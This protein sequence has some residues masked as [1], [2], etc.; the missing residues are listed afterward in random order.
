MNNEA[1]P[2]PDVFDM[3]RSAAAAGPN[4]NDSDAVEPNQSERSETGGLL[5][6]LKKN[7]VPVAIGAAFFIGS[8]WIVMP[9]LFSV[10]GNA[11]TAPQVVLSQPTLSPVDAMRNA[12]HA[13]DVESQLMASQPPAGFDP[14]PP[15]A[16]DASVA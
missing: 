10:G 4:E 16:V 14:E 2:S 13:N 15:A 1:E 3:T 6:K 7:A 9:E 11:S 12:G 5:G 8:V